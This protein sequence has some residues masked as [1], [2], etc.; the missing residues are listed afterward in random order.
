MKSFEHFYIERYD[1]RGRYTYKKKRKM[2]TTYLNIQFINMG[3][4]MVGFLAKIGIT[5]NNLKRTYYFYKQLK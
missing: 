4:K 5:N 3:M 2:I 1:S